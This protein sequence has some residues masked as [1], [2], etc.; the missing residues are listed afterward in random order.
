MKQT[1]VAI[2]YDFD[3]TL[4]K[5]NIQ[6]Y[7]FIPSLNMDKSAFW[8]EVREI[9]VKNESD[10]ILSYMFLMLKKAKEKGISVKKEAFSNFSKEVEFFKGVET[11]FSRIT[12]YGKKEKINISHYIVSSGIKEMIEGTSIAKEFKKIYACSFI[13]DQNG[14]AVSPGNSVNYTN[15]T[16][17]L[18]RINK[19]IL[20]VYDLSINDNIPDSKRRVPFQNMIYIGDGETDIPCMKIVKTF[21]GK[22]I[23]VYDNEEK[24]KVSKKLLEDDRVN[25]IAETDYRENS[26]ID[27]YIKACIEEI[28]ASDRRQTF[29][30]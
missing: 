18:F 9:S 16:Q 10:G 15:K 2:V 24:K 28:K 23:S 5:G 17:F 12:E 19:G 20:D 26:K 14:N 22:S 7:S 30:K 13:Y 21:G 1:E 11:W 4:A 25:Y 6:E 27:K 29:E 3:E 8:K